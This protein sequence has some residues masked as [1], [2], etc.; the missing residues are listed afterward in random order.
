MRQNFSHYYRSMIGKKSSDITTS[1]KL[2]DNKIYRR[3]DEDEDSYGISILTNNTSL[4]DIYLL[5]IRTDNI[6]YEIRYYV[7]NTKQIDL[8]I[9]NIALSSSYNYDKIYNIENTNNE[10]NNLNIKSNIINN[11]I[12]ISDI[13]L[14]DISN[15]ENI[16]FSNITLPKYLKLD[17]IHDKINEILKINLMNSFKLV[18]KIE[19][20]INTPSGILTYLLKYNP[21]NAIL[22]INQNIEFKINLD[23]I[24]EFIKN[25]INIIEYYPYIKEYGIKYLELNKDKNSDD[26]KYVNY[27][28]AHVIMSKLGNL[29]KEE[30]KLTLE[31]LF[32][33]G[34]IEDSKILRTRL[35]F[36]Y[37]G[38]P[39][40]INN[41]FDINNDFTTIMNLGEMIKECNNKL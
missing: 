22:Y 3:K 38:L 1:F 16:L 30:K 35:F 19:E 15:I 34:D 41:K 25:T 12:Y 13:N 39:M 29:T 26:I 23:I 18:S 21:E 37:I 17:T 27:A 36:D 2:D 5:I 24:P 20:N 4:T 33:S 7:H 14:L 31:Y 40:N 8:I 9:A 6:D 10:L 28:L 32:N 11:E